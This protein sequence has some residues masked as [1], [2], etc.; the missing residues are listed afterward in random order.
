MKP[1]FF[2]CCT[3]Y[4]ATLAIIL[5]LTLI[6]PVPATGQHQPDTIFA[7]SFNVNMSKAV[8]QGIFH[9]D[10]DYVY[11]VPDHGIAAV[12]MVPG[13]G[14]KYS[15]LLSSGLDSGEVFQF[16]FRIN[17]SLNETV[18]RSAVA[19]QGTVVINAWWNDDPANITTFRTD[20]TY[21]IA[22]GTFDPE[23]DS[24]DIVGTMNNWQGSGRMLRE[25]TTFV[26]TINYTLD[27]GSVQQY[28]FRINADSSGLELMNQ[29]PRMLR[30]PDTAITRLHYFNNYNPAWLPMTFNCNMKF[31]IES[32][33]F[34]RSSDY[35]DVAGTFNGWGANDVLFDAEADSVYTT[36]LFLDTTMF[37][38]GPLEF[39]FRINGDWNT[40][41]L[42]G[43]PDRTYV[44]HDTT[45]IG[46][47]IFS[48]W[49]DDKDPAIPAPPWAYNVAIQ[50]A[51]INHQVI[52]GSYGYA[53]VNGIPEGISVYRWYQS[54]DSLGTAPVLIDS[55][56]HIGYEIDTTDIGKWLIFEV[57]PIA[58]SGD[59]ATGKPVRVITSSKV[60]GV[61][62]DELNSIIVKVF[63]NP[64]DGLLTMEARQEVTRI[65]I[66]NFLGQVILQETCRNS[67]RNTLSVSQ[68][69]SG[70][71]LLKAYGMHHETG[72]VKIIRK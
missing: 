28:K 6:V 51:L 63:P 56:G 31:Y 42:S 43:K 18:T 17:D 11:V 35:L 37:H 55:A 44:F 72:Q 57:T 47:N 61:G 20:M 30:I 24:L 41:E 1:G 15:F 29:P 70:I 58:A 33:F 2:R 25:D 16:R 48:C 62:L 36:T 52:S 53:N 65:E 21:M 38:P 54:N 7:F 64:T 9:P 49:Y 50:G 8:Q 3:A 26:Y 4:S 5:L 68:L 27:P 13:P 60:G 67:F 69:P 12:R 32:A 23:T 34:D 40:A 66:L 71:Y 39:K 14:Y 46:P 45:G 22:A 19:A 10:S 59:S